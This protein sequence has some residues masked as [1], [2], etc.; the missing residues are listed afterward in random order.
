MSGETLALAYLSLAKGITYLGFFGLVGAV[1]VQLVAVPACRRT[2]AIAPPVSP[3]VDQR[4][5]RVAVVSVVLLACAAVARV[6]AQT[7][8]VF[9]LDE[10]VTLE[11]MQLVALETRWGTQWL[12]QL[13]ATLFV[14]AAV[15]LMLVRP[16]GGW[17]LLAVSAGALA[18]ALPM[19]G[20]AMSHSGGA[21]LPWTLQVGHGVA[22]GL[23]LGTLA[24]V[25]SIVRSSR[26]S[27][28]AELDQL[29]AALVNVFSPLA[30]AGAGTVLVTGVAT[31]SLYFNHWSQLWQ[32]SYGLTLLG[33]V[34]LV[35]ATGAVG[36]YNWRL[37][38]PRLGTASGSV[39]LVRSASLELAFACGVLAVTV[40]LVHLPV[41]HE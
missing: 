27:A 18:V 8:S 7:Y 16:R 1:A 12:P 30:V 13:E 38:R 15:G 33:K 6:Y 37:L 2:G 9:G 35:L 10:P 36:A 34:A 23:W 40:V 21:T 32:T 41:P 24:A 19:T 5:Q 39:T 11:L 14:I 3:L 29:T 25:V 4:I 26:V 28:P 31:A 20:H 17:W 22:G